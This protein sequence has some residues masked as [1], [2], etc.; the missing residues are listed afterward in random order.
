MSLANVSRCM[1]TSV[2]PY[3]VVWAKEVTSSSITFDSIMTFLL[4]VFVFFLHCISRRLHQYNLN[5]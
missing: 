4:P 5:R 1:L 2:H 3:G